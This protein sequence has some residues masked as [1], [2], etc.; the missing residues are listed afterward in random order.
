[1]RRMWGFLIAAF[2]GFATPQVFTLAQG[3]QTGSAADVIRKYE[4]LVRHDAKDDGATWWK[5]A[6][7]YQNTARYK[8]SEHAY[9]RAINLLKTQQPAAIAEVMD[10]MGTM[11]L[12]EGKL[13]RA[14]QLEHSALELRQARNDRTGVGLSWMHLAMV[15]LGEHHLADA[16]MFAELA[17]DRL[18]PELQDRA[19]DGAATPVQK[20]T[21]LTY[22]SHVLCANGRCGESIKVLTSAREIALATYPSESFPVAYL[23]F[24]LGRAHWKNGDLDLA[25]VQMKKGITGMQAE[26]GWGHPTYLEAIKQYGALLKQM[27]R[28][29]EAER[30]LAQ[31]KSA[32]SG[33][34]PSL[35]QMNTVLPQ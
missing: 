15:S 31:E 7:L 20:M 25:A 8:D 23:D 17:V 3:T 18:A 32:P 13:S 10:A 11:Y 26:L 27:G 22:L 4:L 28:A 34:N 16:L 21:A 12:E 30:T 19:K 35:E 29:R 14:E 9:S 1:M 2:V 24:L 6:M 33:T 5:L